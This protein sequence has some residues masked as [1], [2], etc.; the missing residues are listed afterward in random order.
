[1][2][3]T[4]PPESRPDMD[5]AA[6]SCA[7]GSRRALYRQ[8]KKRELEIERHRDKEPESRRDRERR[9]KNKKN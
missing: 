3:G 5:C 7:P 8:Q 6:R 9:K 2:R 4:L 1:M